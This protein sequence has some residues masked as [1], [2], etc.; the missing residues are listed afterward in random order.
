MIPL[1]KKPFENIAGKEKMPITSIISLFNNIYVTLSQTSRGFYVFSASLSKT[2]LE[3]EKLLITS[4][5][6]FSHSVFYPF[7][8]RSTI[9]IKFE[10]V[11]CKFFQVGRF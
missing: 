10:I 6:S 8:E 1:R 2:L 9:L 4:N 5:F 11:V 7:G 3:K